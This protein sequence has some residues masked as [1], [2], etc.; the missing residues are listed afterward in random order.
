MEKKNWSVDYKKNMVADKGTLKLVMEN[1]EHVHDYN[2]DKVTS[3]LEIDEERLTTVANLEEMF[4]EIRTKA[5]MPIVKT[6]T[7]H[8]SQDGILLEA[9][10]ILGDS[11]KITSGP[12]NDWDGPMNRIITHIVGDY[13]LAAEG[14][15]RDHGIEVEWVRKCQDNEFFNVFIEEE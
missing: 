4:T 8:S 3:N 12:D 7:W 11:I 10:S 2:T 6:L 15:L 14:R 1:L 5:D 13:R 9:T